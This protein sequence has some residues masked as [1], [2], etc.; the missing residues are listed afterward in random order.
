V[1]YHCRSASRLLL[2]VS[3]RAFET[4]EWVTVEKLVSLFLVAR[5]GRTLCMGSSDYVWCLCDPLTSL[6][7][8]CY[9]SFRVSVQRGFVRPNS[10]KEPAFSRWLTRL[11]F[12]CAR[13]RSGLFTTTNLGVKSE[14]VIILK[15]AFKRIE[16]L[17]QKK[18]FPGKTINTSNP[19]TD[20][21]KESLRKVAE[22]VGISQPTLSKAFEPSEE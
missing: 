20:L 6:A 4:E 14:F 15:K 22:K 2:W 18:V 1:D 19:E 12:L 10:G 3:A 16:E 11:G 8:S 7:H 21:A 17:T 5:T 9:S 13:C